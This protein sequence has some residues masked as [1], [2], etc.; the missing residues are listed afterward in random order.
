[1]RHTQD[2]HGCAVMKGLVGRQLFDP[3]V[4]PTLVP[5]QEVDRMT[6]CDSG[7]RDQD[8]ALAGIVDLEA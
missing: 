4:D 3:G 7:G 6:P 1:M 2:R 5:Y 8:D